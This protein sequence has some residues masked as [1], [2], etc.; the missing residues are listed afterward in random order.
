MEM[1]AQSTVALD[2]YF[3]RIGYTGD[4]KPSLENLQQ[5]HVRHTQFIPFENLDPFLRR[6][7]RLDLPSLQQKLI[8]EGRGGYCFEHNLLFG[9]VL[10]AMGYGVIGLAARVLWNQPDDAITARGHMLLRV[11][12]DGR[13]YIADTG[14][15]ALTLTAPLRLE[16]GVEQSTPHESFRLMPCGAEFLLHAKVG[17]WRTLYRFAL[18]EQLQPDYEVTNWYLSNHPQS[19]FVT[20]LI[21][22]RP[23]PG[24]RYT[25]HNTELAVHD[26]RAGTERCRLASPSALRAVLED[27][28]QLTLPDE[29]KMDEKLERLCAA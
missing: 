22:A 19:H 17:A 14:F 13:D 20:G 18:H 26:L 9:H 4:L 29:P 28:F 11:E 15:G 6:P 3:A 25:L 10:R 21:A 24:G 16:A 23:A 8:R 27:H 12:V 2:E 1:N 7:V 5:L